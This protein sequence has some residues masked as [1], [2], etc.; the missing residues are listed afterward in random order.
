MST[1]RK[2]LFD[3]SALSVVALTS[4]TKVL[5]GTACPCWGK[6]SLNELNGE[7]FAAQV[8]T[9]F[10][11]LPMPDK[12]MRVKLEAVNLTPDDRFEKFCLI[13]SRNG[14][15]LFSQDHCTFEHEALGRFEMF[16][17]PNQTRDR[18]K[19]NY[20][21]VFDRRRNRAFKAQA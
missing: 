17:V 2:F 5:A 9:T 15:E 10:L 4:P 1:R 7:D 12:A 14:G 11:M 13:F 3:C 8:N 6:R 20:V 18:R 19:T 16:I 21:A